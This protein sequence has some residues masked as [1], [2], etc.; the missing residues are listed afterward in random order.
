MTHMPLASRSH[1]EMNTALQ[2]T[3]P[4]GATVQ[5]KAWIWLVHASVVVALL[6]ATKFWYVY[7]AVP[8]VLVPAHASD[9]YTASL[10]TRE[11]RTQAPV[12][13]DRL[14]SRAVHAR[15]LNVDTLTVAARKGE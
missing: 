8:F 1:G 9:A 13:S 4:P 11:S 5:L 12:L 15:S 14:P 7:K 3:H 2:G 10:L 6:S